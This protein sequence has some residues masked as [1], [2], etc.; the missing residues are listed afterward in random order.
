MTR[1]FIL[2]ALMA[3]LS[4]CVDTASGYQQA[5]LS[6]HQNRFNEAQRLLQPLAAIGYAPAQYHLALLQHQQTGLW[7]ATAMAGLTQAA[8]TGHLGARYQ[9]ALA[10]REAGSLTHAEQSLRA[11]A[12]EGFVPAQF[13]LARLLENRVDPNAAEWFR[14]AAVAG[15]EGAVTRLGLAHERGELGLDK[16]LQ[17]AAAWREQL[18]VKKF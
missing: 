14:R 1:A 9:L 3:C 18:K 17:Q 7:N 6:L 8:H 4:G 10:Q 2:L 5:M 15:H 12:E 11:L 13:E 16:D